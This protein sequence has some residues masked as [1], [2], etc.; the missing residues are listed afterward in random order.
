L[1]N[2]GLNEADATGGP[3]AEYLPEFQAAVS[4]LTA[5]LRPV[6]GLATMP[7]TAHAALTISPSRMSGQFT[8]STPSS[9]RQTTVTRVKPVRAQGNNPV[10]RL[11]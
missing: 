2:V 4:R 3:V 8:P 6:R 10:G 7:A 1:S 11:E 5:T 9:R